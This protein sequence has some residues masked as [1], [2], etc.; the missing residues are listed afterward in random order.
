MLEEKLFKY[1]FSFI[2]LLSQSFCSPIVTTIDATA[3]S[4]QFIPKGFCL[5]PPE[6]GYSG[7]I[8]FIEDCSS[9]GRFQMVP[10]PGNT[11]QKFGTH[12]I[13][14]CPQHLSN[15][16]ICFESDGWCPNYKPPVYEPE[17]LNKIED[18]NNED[19][20][21]PLVTDP[22]LKI[23]ENYK[24]LIISATLMGNLLNTRE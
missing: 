7:E 12:P 6:Q 1:L 2:F 10:L 23:K 9:L 21:I 22:T 11:F 4:I 20:S 17:D 3:A 18:E 15:S 19:E 14:C 16:A 24:W 5:L 8:K 13:V